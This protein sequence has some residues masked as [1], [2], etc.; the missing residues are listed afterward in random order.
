MKRETISA[1]LNG[2]DERF[3]TEAA[4]YSPGGIQERPERIIAMKKKRLISA[5]LAAALVLA[6]GITAY[7]AWSVHNARQQEIKDDLKIEENRV[8]AFTEYSVP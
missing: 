2:L 7:A 8:T 5:A 3:I 1:A 6:L 4:S